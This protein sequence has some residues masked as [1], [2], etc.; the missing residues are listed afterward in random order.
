MENTPFTKYGSLWIFL[1]LLI[2]T[3]LLCQQAT[4]QNFPI[5]VSVMQASV[6]PPSAGAFRYPFNPAVMVGTEYIL[7]EKGKSDWH[8]AANLGWFYHRNLQTGFLLNGEIGYRYRLGR[9]HVAPR[10]GLGYGHTFSTEPVYRLENSE[11]VRVKDYGNPTFLPSLSVALGYRLGDQT[12]SPEIFLTWQQM[13]E[14]PFVFFTGLHQFVGAGI[15]FHPFS[16]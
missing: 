7:S 1:F 6:S 14:V 13:A 9:F 10:L 12:T 11:P 5:K 8:L 2:W 15:K 16:N 3:A 4:A